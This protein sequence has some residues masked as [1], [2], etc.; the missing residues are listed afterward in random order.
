M[1]SIATALLTVAI[2]VFG[3]ITP[4]S[5]ATLNSDKLSLSYIRVIRPFMT[6]MT[7]FIFII[8]VFSRAILF[9]FRID[10]NAILSRSSGKCP[11]HLWA[12]DRFFTEI[13]DTQAVCL[14]PEIQI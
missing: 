1:V 4:K 9:L 7:P 14:H 10:P 2:L 13:S 6:I 12:G 8:N 11:L 5:I 3:E